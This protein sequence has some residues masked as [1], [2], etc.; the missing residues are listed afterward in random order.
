MTASRLERFECNPDLHA[1]SKH[2]FLP[3]CQHP[4]GTPRRAVWGESAFGKSALL[5]A[6]P[7][8]FS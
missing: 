3:A 7:L 8:L 1:M 6:A 5:T 2:P 4:A